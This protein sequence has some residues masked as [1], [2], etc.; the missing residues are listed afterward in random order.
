LFQNLFASLIDRVD[1]KIVLGATASAGISMSN[2]A[3]CL[4]FFL[5]CPKA[6]AVLYFIFVVSLLE[7]TW[8]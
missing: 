1:N 8:N 6:G 5:C 3:V 7:H 2:M 4:L